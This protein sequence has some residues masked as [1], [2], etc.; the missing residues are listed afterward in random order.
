MEE[1]KSMYTTMPT[2]TTAAIRTSRKG[3]QSRKTKEFIRPVRMLTSTFAP[4]F[5]T[6]SKTEVAMPV[7]S[8]R[9][10]SLK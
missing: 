7:I 5:S 4:W 6:T 8:P 2:S 1:V 9:L 3:M 10:L